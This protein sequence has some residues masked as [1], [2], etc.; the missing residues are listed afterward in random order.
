MEDL[1][2][3]AA[4]KMATLSL[5]FGQQSHHLPHRLC[6]GLYAVY[7]SELSSPLSILIVAAILNGN[8][9][10]R[11]NGSRLS[12]AHDLVSPFYQ[13]GGQSLHLAQTLTV[14]FCL[15]YP[16]SGNL[17][18]VRSLT[19][20]DLFAVQRLRPSQCHSQRAFVYSFFRPVQPL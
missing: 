5:V 13:Y 20:I 1:G 18:H 8:E 19:K 3:E 9:E 10:L 15:L 12:L 16:V 6:H 2:D 11:E 17:H 14:D 4:L 7:L